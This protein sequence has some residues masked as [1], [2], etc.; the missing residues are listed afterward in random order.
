[1]SRYRIV[2]VNHA[3]GTSYWKYFYRVEKRVFGCLWWSKVYEKKAD[4]G[5]EAEVV[6][7]CLNVVRG[8]IESSVVWDSKRDD[9]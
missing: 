2:N 5:P 6:A 3:K 9:L 1:M 4:Y 8:R 7:A